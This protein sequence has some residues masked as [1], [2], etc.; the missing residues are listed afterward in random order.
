[1][2]MH[3]PMVYDDRGADWLQDSE[4]LLN[5]YFGAMMLKC[6]DIKEKL[7]DMVELPKANE[8][9]VLD[10]E[11]TQAI[12]PDYFKLQATLAADDFEGS[13]KMLKSMMQKSG[14]SGTLADLLHTM[15]AAKDLEGIRRPHFET[16]SNAMIKA[17]KKHP[18]S[19]P[20][21]VMIMHCPMVYGETGADWLQDNDKL[22]NPYFGASMLRCGY[23]KEQLGK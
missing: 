2:V 18:S 10:A 19:T 22:L 21:S 1:M 12:L 8:E 13:K 23:Q 6:G 9:I 4:P 16:L 20:G 17:V 5:P 14:H 7:S 3:C 15:M 11:L